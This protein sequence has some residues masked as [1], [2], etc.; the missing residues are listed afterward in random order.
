MNS[1]T[2]I[3]DPIGVIAL[4][5]ALSEASAATVLP[6]LDD[7]NRQVYIWFLIIFPSFLVL[8][9]FLTLNF[10]PAALYPPSGCSANDEARAVDCRP[11]SSQQ[12]P[13]SSTTYSEGA[14]KEPLKNTC[15]EQ[16][17]L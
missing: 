12:N 4:F 1:S 11:S 7:Q 5:A 14:T 6:H 3:M 9:F 2:R 16:Q 17:N 15:D 8:M 13:D 10:N